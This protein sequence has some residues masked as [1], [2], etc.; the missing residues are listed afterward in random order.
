MF[1]HKLSFE[2]AATADEMDL[3]L[4]AATSHEFARDR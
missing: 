1:G 2:P 4:R 3:V